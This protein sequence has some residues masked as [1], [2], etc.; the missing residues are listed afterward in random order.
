MERVQ[1]W[2]DKVREM[3]SYH[4]YTVRLYQDEN[5]LLIDRVRDLEMQ[6]DQLRKL[7]RAPF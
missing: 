1:Y 4:K 5:H 6:L 7:R 2:E 3:A